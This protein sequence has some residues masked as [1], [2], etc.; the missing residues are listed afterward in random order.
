MAAPIVRC[1]TGFARKCVRYTK[2]RTVIKQN[3]QCH[4]KACVISQKIHARCFIS[5]FAV[6]SIFGFGLKKG[7]T[8]ETEDGVTSSDQSVIETADQ[9]Y[10]GN[11]MIKL[12]DFLL[13]YSDSNNGDIAWRLARATC[14]KAKLTGDKTERKKLMYEAFDLA[15]KA[16]TLDENNS[17]CHKWY[18][19]L[20]DY[21]GEYE[22]TKFRI[23]H[24]YEMKEHFLKAMELNPKDATTIHSIGV[25][26]FAFADLP[27]YQRK[28]AAALFATPPSSTYEEALHYFEKAEEVEPDFYSMNLLMLGKT[29]LRLGNKEQALIY[30]ARARNYPVKTPDDEQA[31]KESADLLKKI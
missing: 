5:S 24:S 7:K 25:W 3:V 6:V 9:L 28:L 29:H 23:S 13:G 26:C 17:S 11:Q 22:G 15:Q 31:H 30:L 10:K 4:H 18:A 19:I 1:W 8:S 14:D 20:L 27:W 21:K 16:L 12:Y 2:G